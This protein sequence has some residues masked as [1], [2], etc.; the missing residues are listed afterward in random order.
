MIVPVLVSVAC[1]MMST[2]STLDTSTMNLIESVELVCMLCFVIEYIVC[3]RKKG[4]S[5]L[6]SLRGVI[7]ILTIAPYFL[8]QGLDLRSL[9]LVRVI[10]AILSLQK[11]IGHTK[12]SS[13]LVN[14]I[15]GIMVE[16]RVFLGVSAS[17]I[18]FFSFGIYHL[19]HDIQPLVF[20]S[21]FDAL[22]FSSITLT[23]V[24]Y[25]D[26]VPLSSGGK[27]LTALLA[28]LGTGIVTIPSA[29]IAASLVTLK[30]R[31]SD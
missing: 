30:T 3:A 24:G 25:G 6:L 2:I 1:Y 9:K 29:M 10:N 16:L 27:L 8:T 22:W 5:Y 28:I 20:E 18:L 21:V 11:S 13:L 26:I 17:L 23:T 7:D 19:E 15:Q 31:A 4:A 12:A 14:A